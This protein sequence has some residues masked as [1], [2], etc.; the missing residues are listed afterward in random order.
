[1]RY[2]WIVATKTISWFSRI[3]L[4]HFCVYYLQCFLRGLP[5]LCRYMPAPK[6]ARRQIP[7]PDNEPDLSAISRLY[8][9]PTFSTV[10]ISSMT[11][12]TTTTT[13]P[14]PVQHPSDVQ[15]EQNQAS[16]D[17]STMVSPPV[18]P[19]TDGV[20][21]GEKKG[22]DRAAALAE[23]NDLRARLA[24]K[25]PSSSSS[26]NAEDGLPPA[27]RL[28]LSSPVLATG[29]VGQ[30]P[31]SQLLPMPQAFPSRLG[32]SDIESMLQ[33]NAIINVMR[34]QQE[35]QKAIQEIQVQQKLQELCTRHKLQEIQQQHQLQEMN[36]QQTIQKLQI[37]QQLKEFQ[38]QQ[39][40]EEL[41][42]IKAQMKLQGLQEGLPLGPSI[43]T[44]TT[45]TTTN[46][47]TLSGGMSFSPTGGP[48]GLSNSTIA[49][50]LRSK[51]R[52]E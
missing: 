15:Q 11:T 5:H 35:E 23:I 4:L 30:I 7:D 6:D 18:L 44:T 33:T 42:K 38:K 28:A 43:S 31:V 3:P 50:F 16:H 24:S 34:T 52:F 29:S 27:K 1:M 2:G 8:P 13:A 39:A 37:Q 19:Q 45:T 21:T 26:S 22:M 48:A 10:S 47:P 46:T 32:V 12:T 9:V 51:K 20:G 49:E 25:I 36:A 40:L 14:A 17:S 41:Q